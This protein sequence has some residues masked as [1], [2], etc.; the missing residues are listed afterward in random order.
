M[1]VKDLT[2]G[3]EAQFGNET[4]TAKNAKEGRYYFAV[5]GIKPTK[6][7]EQ[8]TV[9]CG[10]ADYTFAPLAWSFRAVNA[11]GVPESDA[12]MANI[13]YACYANAKAFTNT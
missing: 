12:A 6:L 4:L 8:I 9:S 1:Y 10:G 13:L 11:T 7:S 2:D 3:T 5:T